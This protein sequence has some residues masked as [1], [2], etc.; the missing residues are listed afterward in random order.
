MVRDGRFDARIRLDLPNESERVEVLTAQLRKF[1]WK[2]HDLTAIAKRTPGWS[3]ARLKSLVDRA[4]LCAQEKVIEERHVIEALESTGGRDQ[5]PLEPVGWDDVVLPAAVVDDLR[6]LLDLMKPGRAEELSLPAPDGS[7]SCWAAW[8]RQN[9]GSEA[10]RVP[11][12]AQ[13]LR[14]EPERCLGQRRGRVCQGGCRRSSEERRTTRLPSYS[15]TRWMACSPNIMARMNQHDV[16]LVE[17]ALIEISALK[18]EH[19]IFLVG[20][21][22]YL[23]RIDPRILRGGRFSEKVVVPVPDEAGYRKLVVRYLGKTRLGRELTIQALAERV[24]GMAPAD[25]EATI[26]SMKRVAMR[27]MDPNAK[28]LP[29]LNMGDLD[30]A[31]GRVQPRF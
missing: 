30:E 10:D 21:T 22:N 26:Q 14:G 4:A 17:Q 11:S 29:P 12:Q 13:F 9:I 2:N 23:D 28:E 8:N 18:P 16:Q 1:P 31:L 20:T 27:R 25:L 6:A 24:T 3:P 7:H 5:G 19:Q 15:S